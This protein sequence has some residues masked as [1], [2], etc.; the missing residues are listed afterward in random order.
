MGGR[1]TACFGSFENL[2]LVSAQ[3]G[4]L[5]VGERCERSVVADQDDRLGFPRRFVAPHTR[6]IR[7]HSR[8]GDTDSVWSPFEKGHYRSNGHMTFNDIAIDQR[9]VARGGIDRNTDLCLERNK[10]PILLNL[11]TRSVVL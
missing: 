6:R 2:A 10:A 11:D 8:H 4:G 7:G 1:F 3:A 9:R 5:S